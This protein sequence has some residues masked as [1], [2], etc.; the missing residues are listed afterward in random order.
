MD[1][2]ALEAD[3]FSA[4]GDASSSSAT[5]PLPE[6]CQDSAALVA[7][8]QKAMVLEYNFFDRSDLVPFSSSPHPCTARQAAPPPFLACCCT[9]A[10]DRLLPLPQTHR[11]RE[12][13]AGQARLQ[14][15]F[16]YKLHSRF[17]ERFHFCF[18]T[19]LC[20]DCYA[21]RLTAN[22]GLAKTSLVQRPPPRTLALL[23]WRGVASCSS[24]TSTKP[25]RWRILVR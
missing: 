3:Q 5:P 21:S 1:S 17:Q 12:R 22:A 18:P 11:C 16:L 4:T 6:A 15:E 24:L 14:G 8:Y 9:E 7:L 13:G 19:A 10:G 23:L 25:A 2:L 20:H